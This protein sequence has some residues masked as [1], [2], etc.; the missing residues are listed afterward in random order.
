MASDKIRKIDLEKLAD[1]LPAIT[2]SLGASLAEAGAICFAGQ[3]HTVGVELKVDGEYIETFK[4]YW[5]IIT[6]Q[7][8][9]CWN[10]EEVTTE[11]GAYA[12]AFLLIRSLTEFTVIERSRKG[13][14]FDYWLGYEDD[15]IPFQ[16][17]ARLEISGIRKGNDR[18]VKA[19]IKQKINQAKRSGGLL[20]V[21]IIVVEFGRPLSYVVKK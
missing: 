9:R 14:G 11:H 16:N 18:V 13:I 2:P 8:R 1:G 5:P 21:F 10:D 15:E 6:E 17:R 4:V 19:R 20:R 12:V 7:M 3:G